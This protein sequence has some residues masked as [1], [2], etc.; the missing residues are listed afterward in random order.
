MIEPELN[1]TLIMLIPK[2]ESPEDFSHFRPISLCSVLYK[3]VM[4]V[5]AN[6][7]KVIFPKLISQEQAGFIAGRNIPGN[8]ILAQ[9]V[10]HSMR[11]NRKGRKLM[12]IK[13]DL[14][15][16]YERVSWEFISASLIAA[17][18]PVF[19]QNVIM[20]SISSSS[21]QIL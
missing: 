20:P 9:K 19:L 2:K 18:I 3:L 14:E 6:R 21:V 11:C 1:N 15:K 5:I 4:K 16:T 13:L 12:A 7:F 10:I 8:I 17:G